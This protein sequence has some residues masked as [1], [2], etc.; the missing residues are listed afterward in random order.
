MK[1]FL[2]FFLVLSCFIGLNGF[3]QT[4]IKHGLHFSELAST[5]DE[6]IPLGNGMVGSLI[7][8]KGE[9]LRMS[10]DRADLWDMRPMKD[11]HRKE[12]S[13][14]WVQEQVAKKD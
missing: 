11:I 3:S 12:F 14:K 8:Q 4:V 5:W 9:H 2:K 6:A 1:F 10:L 7:W 13:Y